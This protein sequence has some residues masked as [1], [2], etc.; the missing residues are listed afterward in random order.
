[1]VVLARVPPT[2]SRIVSFRECLIITL[3]DART[4]SSRV[5]RTGVE[6][7][8]LPDLDQRRGAR[9]EPGGRQHCSALRSEL[10]PAQ[11]PAGQCLKKTRKV[12]KK[13][14]KVVLREITPL[15]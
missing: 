15:I 10:E 1:M 4:G 11:R 12:V 13:T 8:H 7:L 9:T 5:Q 14:R 2:Y 3:D 6:S